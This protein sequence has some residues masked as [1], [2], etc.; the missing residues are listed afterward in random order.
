MVRE[1]VQL[2]QHST[3]CEHSALLAGAV[4][5]SLL[6]GTD[7]SWG[8]IHCPRAFPLVSLISCVSLQQPLHFLFTQKR[9]NIKLVIDFTSLQVWQYC[10]EY[11]AFSPNFR[12]ISGLRTDKELNSTLPFWSTLEMCTEF[13]TV[14]YYNS[15]MCI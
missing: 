9:K 7:V 3:F 10:W 1:W 4:F 6:Y 5:S 12:A 8:F 15:S 14:I 2:K 13:S 11:L